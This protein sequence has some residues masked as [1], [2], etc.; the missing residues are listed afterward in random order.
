MPITDLVIRT[1]RICA[2]FLDYR[3]AQSQLQS[4]HCWLYTERFRY[5]N[6]QPE[7]KNGQQAACHSKLHKGS[8]FSSFCFLGFTAG[9]LEEQSKAVPG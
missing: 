2:F 1:A 3:A 6:V 5:S 4:S 7:T 8:A 9:V